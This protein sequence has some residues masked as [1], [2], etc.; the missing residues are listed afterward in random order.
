MHIKNKTLAIIFCLLMLASMVFS[1]I[2][3]ASAGY[4][5]ETAAAISQGM[6]WPPTQDSA[7]AYRNASTTRL[8][9][10]TR[11]HDEVPTA[12]F[13][14]ATPKPVGVGQQMTFIFFNPQV[15]NPSTDR[16]LFDLTIS[17][18]DGTTEVLPPAGAQG[19]YNQPI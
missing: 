10:W 3:V 13:V 15:P 19:I 17:K 16:Y 6:H 5:T 14:S 8:L 12:V 18:P 2:P 1:L 7:T 9:M 4:S 11:W